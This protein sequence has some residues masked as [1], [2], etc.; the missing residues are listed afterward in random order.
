MA[1]ALEDGTGRGYGGDGASVGVSVFL[2]EVHAVGGGILRW[3]TVSGSV[4][5]A[6]LFGTGAD[7]GSGLGASQAGG[8]GV[9]GSGS[10]GAM[11]VA[12]D[13][14]YGRSGSAW[15]LLR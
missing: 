13:E 10:D 3:A 15:T 8:W 6:A 2:C 9:A 1:A 11:R 5:C 12:G 7:A 14:F 4:N